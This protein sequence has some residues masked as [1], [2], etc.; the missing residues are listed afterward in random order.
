MEGLAGWNKLNG[1]CRP[2][3]PPALLR[4]KVFTGLLLVIYRRSFSETLQPRPKTATK[5]KDLELPSSCEFGP[6]LLVPGTSYL[7]NATHLHFQ[8]E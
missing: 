8:V 4:E 1:L 6:D 7:G 3:P 2:Q 5:L